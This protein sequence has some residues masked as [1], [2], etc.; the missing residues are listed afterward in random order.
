MARERVRSTVTRWWWVRHAPVVVN[1]GRIYGRTDLPCVTDDSA[2]FRGLAAILP[3]DAV[4][5]VSDLMRTHQTAQAI[6]DA[7]LPGPPRIPGEGV[8]VEA[9]LAEQDFGEWHG[10]TYA[11]LAEHRAEQFHRF[12]HAPAHERAPGGESFEDLLARVGPV[13]D[14]FNA[15]FAGR[16]IIAVAHG[17]TIRSAI[18]KA[19]DLA[20]E[21]ALAFMTDNVSVT[22]LDHFAGGDDLGHAWRVS[23]LNRPPV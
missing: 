16:D 19:L 3:R 6:V 7:G 1:N 9:D 13:I 8:F 20:P 18:A 14:R 10:R 21:T 4:W 12:W 22:R 17:G 11:W 2:A 23:C 15:D 5:V